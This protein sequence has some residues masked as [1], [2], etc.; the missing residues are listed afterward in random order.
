LKQVGDKVVFDFHNNGPKISEE[1]IGHLFERFYRE[2]KARDRASGGT[3]L[4]LSIAHN[5]AAAHG[6]T[7]T[8]ENHPDGG[9]VFRLTLPL[10]GR[11]L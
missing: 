3:G 11:E 5:L 8:G 2:D 4:G 9:V 1:A 10:T 6:G 7:L